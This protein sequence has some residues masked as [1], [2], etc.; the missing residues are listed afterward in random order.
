MRLS[1]NRKKISVKLREVIV[2]IKRDKYIII[3][4]LIIAI[5]AYVHVRYEMVQNKPSTVHELAPRD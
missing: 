1:K 4:A 3:A 5:A 2:I